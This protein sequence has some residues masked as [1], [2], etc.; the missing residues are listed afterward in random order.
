MSAEIATINDLY[1]KINADPHE[2]QDP[3]VAH[4]VIDHNRVLGMHAVPGLHMDAK[5]GREIRCI[6]SKKLLH[7]FGHIHKLHNHHP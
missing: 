4:L 5:T 3:D 2:L 6:R 1:D 7:D